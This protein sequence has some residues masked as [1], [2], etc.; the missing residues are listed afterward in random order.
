MIENRVLV[1]GQYWGLHDLEW[2][3]SVVLSCIAI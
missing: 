2:N 1:Y 3:W